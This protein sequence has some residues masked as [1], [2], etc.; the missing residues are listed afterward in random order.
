MDFD[1]EDLETNNNNNYAEV[2]PMQDPS[3]PS[4]RPRT[5]PRNPLGRQIS[6]KYR[7]DMN[8]TTFDDD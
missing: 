4:A 5:A 1:D 8:K 2:A 6:G 7:N 3:I